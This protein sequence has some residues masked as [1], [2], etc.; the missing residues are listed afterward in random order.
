VA[1]RSL[2]ALLRILPLSV[3]Y[4]IVE[5]VLLAFYRL[6]RYRE[7]SLASLEIAFGGEMSQE[8]REALFWRS[9][10]YQA[11][12]F[13]DV[14]LADSLLASPKRTRSL[15]LQTWAEARERHDRE[16]PETGAILV[17]GHVGT[18]EAASLG[19]A[20]AFWPHVGLARRLDNRLVW[21]WFLR[22]RERYDRPTLDR[23][24]VLRR[25]LTHLRQGGSVG[26]LND[27]NAGP[28]G[29]FVPYFGRLAST[30]AGAAALAVHTGAPIYVL[31]FPR[32]RPRRFEARAEISG[33]F[34]ADP[35]AD[36]DAE[37]HRLTAL[38]T[39][40]IEAMVR[41][42]PEQALWAH[43]RWKSR[44]PEESQPS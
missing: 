27:Q 31:C 35:D 33:P 28:R 18:P 30:H 39:A 19:G 23:N 21:E 12:F 25:A 14:L 20:Q 29:E 22:E 43:R 40:E 15:D 32:T 38:I 8:E 24:G 34:F 11:W 5:T 1:L 7:R 36:K 44:P 37:I 2:R 9:V 4:R 17:T 13:V 6:S 16:H 3:S 26:M 10:R 41:R 42:H